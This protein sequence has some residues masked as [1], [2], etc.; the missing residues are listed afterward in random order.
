MTDVLTEKND[1]ILV[2]DR[3]QDPGNMGTLI[4]TAA[5]AGIDGIVVLK[6]CVDIYNLKVLR[7]T[8]GA[9]FSIP[10]ITRLEKDLFREKIVAGD[11]YLVCTDIAGEKYYYEVTYRQP[12]VFVI[13]NEA[14]GIAEDLLALA[15]CRVK[16]PM[17]GEI[18]SLN[19]AVSG[20]IVLYDYLRKVKQH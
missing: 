18:D 7:A 11:Y 10:I 16:I 12:T 4:R 14:Q 1:S 5:G 15:S 2:L 17:A 19:A 9:V 3:I 6:G 20:G 8:M 13:G